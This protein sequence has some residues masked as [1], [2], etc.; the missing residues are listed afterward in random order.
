MAKA[1]PDALAETVA[2]FIHDEITMVYGAPREILS[3]NGS[4]LTSEIVNHYLHLLKTKHRV[5]TPYYP[6]TNRKIENFNGL[7]GLTLI[8]LLI[9]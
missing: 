9:N 6:R 8:R 4:N 7:L 5:T 1:V 3:D 2:T